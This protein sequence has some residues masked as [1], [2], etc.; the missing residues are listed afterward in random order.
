M[1]RR[2]IDR[3]RRDK[4][5]HSDPAVRLAALSDLKADD[6][7]SVLSELARHDADDNVRVAA[8]VTSRMCS[9]CLGPMRP[10]GLV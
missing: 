9:Q 6:P 4:W 8:V 7:E 3:F 2:L 1:I 10:G 5:R